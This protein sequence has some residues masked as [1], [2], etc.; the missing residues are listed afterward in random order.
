L[1]A[2]GA[3][4]LFASG[5]ALMGA[6][7][8]TTCIL[9]VLLI[10][11][12][13]IL[14]FSVIAITPFFARDTAGKAS[15]F[16]S[17][18]SSDTQSIAITT[19]VITLVNVGLFLAWTFVGKIGPKQGFIS[20][21]FQDLSGNNVTVQAPICANLKIQFLY[22]LFAVNMVMLLLGIGRSF[23]AFDK[24]KVLRNLPVLI[25]GSLMAIALLIITI[26][27]RDRLT[28][29]RVFG[30][31]LMGATLLV[32]LTLLIPKMLARR[33]KSD[34]RRAS[35]NN[36]FATADRNLP[37]SFI[38]PEPALNL[39]EEED[40]ESP[41][42]PSRHQSMHQTQYFQ[43][44]YQSRPLTQAS[45]MNLPIQTLD[46]KSDKTEFK[47]GREPDDSQHLPESRTPVDSFLKSVMFHPP[48]PAINSEIPQG[49]SNLR[50][51]TATNPA[52]ASL[53]N[54]ALKST[55]QSPRESYAS[56]NTYWTQR[57]SEYNRDQDF[58]EVPAGDAESTL[59][60]DVIQAALKQRYDQ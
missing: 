40:V 47:F 52:V 26:I 13:F 3:T 31:V 39:I 45:S 49:S 19:S 24:P 11:L 58:E 7:S 32:S 22:T 21:A 59:N 42:A 41:V 53:R 20:S 60:F 30:Y 43:S 29:V 44:V 5:Y 35:Q 56:N 36:E 18:Q 15:F 12:G 9:Q 50:V 55:Y 28:M 34:L 46:P 48:P 51:Q 2:L 27:V 54:E 37:E 38:E 10:M 4:F 17:D 23:V 6:P 57:Q 1:P 16:E 8:P 14:F 33:E 25:L